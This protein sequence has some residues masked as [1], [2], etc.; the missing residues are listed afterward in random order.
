MLLDKLLEA[1]MD[2]DV[3]R[4]KAVLLESLG[5][6]VVVDRL[7][8]ETERTALHMAAAW[9]ARHAAR[10]LL[11]HGAQI[12]ITDPD[13]HTPLHLAAAANAGATLR[14]LLEAVPSTQRYQI[15][16]RRDRD[17]CTALHLAAEQGLCDCCEALLVLGQA[18]A[19][20]G[21]LTIPHATAMDLAMQTE[22]HEVLRLLQDHQSQ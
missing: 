15:V 18:D 19:S 21:L 8:P 1:A 3:V 12:A 17:G 22:H 5:V 20:L 6:A 4:L 10:V 14:V 16:N 2:D 11:G 13:G 9:N 7:H